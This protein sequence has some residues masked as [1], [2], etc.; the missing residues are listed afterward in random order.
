M[1]A[2]LTRNPVSGLKHMCARLLQSSD[3]AQLFKFKGDVDRLSDEQR[4]EVAG[5]LC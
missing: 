1:Y 4:R 5:H 3:Y 2:Y